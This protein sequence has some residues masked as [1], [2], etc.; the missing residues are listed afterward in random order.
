VLVIAGTWAYSTSFRGVFV[1]DD[2]EAIVENQHLKSLWPLSESM[3]APA[4]ST[5][6]G[7]P[8]A[9]FTLAFNYALAP[10]NARDVMAPAVHH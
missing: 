9:A 6:A 10:A 2:G 8:V 3:S 7:R 1:W 4:F 5:V